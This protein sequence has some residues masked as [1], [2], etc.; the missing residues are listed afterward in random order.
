LKVFPGDTPPTREILMD[1]T[2]GDHITLSTLRSTVHLGA[3]VDGENHYAGKKAPG[4]GRSVDQWP[5]ERFVGPCRVVSA[6]REAPG[7]L[8]T[9]AGLPLEA[10]DQP[11]LLLRTGTHPDP[12]RWTGDFAGLEPALID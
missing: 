9:L 12:T 10:V 6:R 2:R 4:G 5:L 8:V 1:T 7:G 11:R 3:H